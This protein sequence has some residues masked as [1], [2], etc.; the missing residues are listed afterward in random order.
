ME[1]QNSNEEAATKANLCNELDESLHEMDLNLGKKSDIVVESSNMPTEKEEETSNHIIHNELDDSV[2]EIDLNLDNDRAN[3]TQEEIEEEEEDLCQESSNH[4][5]HNELD[6]SVHEIN[7]LENEDVGEK[8][9]KEDVNEE[10]CIDSELDLSRHEVNLEAFPSTKTK[11]SKLPKVNIDKALTQEQKTDDKIVSLTSSSNEAATSSKTQQNSSALKA[12]ELHFITGSKDITSPTKTEDVNEVSDLASQL[13]FMTKSDSSKTTVTDKSKVRTNPSET[14]S[15]EMTKNS[16]KKSKSPIKHI[17]AIFACSVIAVLITIAKLRVALRIFCTYDESMHTYVVMKKV[18]QCPI[19]LEQSDDE[20]CPFWKRCD[21]IGDLISY[22]PAPAGK[23]RERICRGSFN[24][25]HAISTFMH[26]SLDYKN[27]MPQVRVDSPC[28]DL[29]EPKK[30]KLNILQKLFR[31]KE[32]KEISESTSSD[33][34]DWTLFVSPPFELDLSPKEKNLAQKVTA[35]LQSTLAQKYQKTESDKDWL[36]KKMDSVAYGGGKAPWWLPV[37]DNFGKDKEAK[38][39]RQVAS[40]M[41]IMHWPEVCFMM[42]SMY[43]V[44][45][46]V[47]IS[48]FSI[49]FISSN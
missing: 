6:D 43:V 37:K 48:L 15:K 2:H 24:V 22:V 47:P 23:K 8:E 45:H 7:I 5:I 13:V 35:N 28:P 30:K 44:L 12:S 20:K 49:I 21:E 19:L 11:T 10:D 26:P 39:L 25:L 4:I 1:Q 32:M 34:L 38:G 31:K 17:I 36:E 41:K 29:P 18:E 3:S 42:N 27:T 9:E 16:N 46:F 14:K 40:Y 33:E